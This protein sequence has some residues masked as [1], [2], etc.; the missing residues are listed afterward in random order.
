MAIKADKLKTESDKFNLLGK[1][2]ESSKF[3]VGE[4]VKNNVISVEDGKAINDGLD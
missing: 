4:L 3:S 2:L 1:E